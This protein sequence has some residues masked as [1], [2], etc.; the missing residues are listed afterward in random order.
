M[1]SASSR[2]KV[3]MPASN[4]EIVMHRHDVDGPV[5][6]VAASVCGAI[7]KAVLRSKVLA[8]LVERMREISD[9]SRKQRVA[10]GFEGELPEVSISDCRVLQHQTVDS[11]CADC[12]HHDV[13]LLSALE[14]LGQSDVTR[15]IKTVAEHDQNFSS[16]L[17]RKH[18][19]GGRRNCIEQ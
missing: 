8:D 12:I 19:T 15:I 16:S 11:I 13:V 1:V 14:R 6:A 10:T 3:T 7:R 18:V 17:A 9:R 4:T 2:R 5:G